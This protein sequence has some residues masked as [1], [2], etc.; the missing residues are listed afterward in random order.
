MYHI[1][2]STIRDLASTLISSETL[3]KRLQ[4]NVRNNMCKI[5]NKQNVGMQYRN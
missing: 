2:A 1:S 5:I 4:I 3:M